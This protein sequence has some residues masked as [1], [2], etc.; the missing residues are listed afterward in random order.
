MEDEAKRK[1][2]QFEDILYSILCEA[3]LIKLEE[4]T[5]P[6]IAR[7]EGYS[8]LFLALSLSLEVMF[9]VRRT[10]ESMVLCRSFYNSSP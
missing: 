9:K 4:A 2:Q 8:S 10:Y 1:R 7:D 6:K 3:R 5:R